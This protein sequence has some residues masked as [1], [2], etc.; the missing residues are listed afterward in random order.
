MSMDCLRRIAER[1]LPYSVHDWAEIDNL[2]VLRAAGM[3]SAF[4]PPPIDLPH[5][6]QSQKPAQVLAI[7][8]KGR[9]ALRGRI[10]A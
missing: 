10:A 3:I 9:Q 6:E 4:L 5:G 8:E 7:T 2:R 1:D